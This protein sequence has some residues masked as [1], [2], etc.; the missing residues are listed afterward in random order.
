MPT[1]VCATH[2]RAC[3]CV[4]TCVRVRVHARAYGVHKLAAMSAKSHSLW[5]VWSLYSAPCLPKLVNLS[6]CAPGAGLPPDYQQISVYALRLPTNTIQHCS[7]SPPNHVLGHAI[8]R[9]LQRHLHLLACHVGCGDGEGIIEVFGFSK[10]D[11]PCWAVG[12]DRP[13]FDP[14]SDVIERLLFLLLS[15]CGKWRDN[16]QR[17]VLG[18]DEATGRIYI[19]SAEMKQTRGTVE[20]N[21]NHVRLRST[22]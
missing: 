7:L 13:T 21:L 1:L 5:P 2:A 20:T 19:G 16:K 18:A 22:G 9:S 11:W 15:W 3:A 6:A 14:R 12:C 10:D 8:V 4:R 17:Q